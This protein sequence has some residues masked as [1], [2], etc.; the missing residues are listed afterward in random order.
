VTL[1]A[2]LYLRVSTDKQSTENQRP[3]VELLAKARAFEVTQVYEETMSAAKSRPIFAQ[4]PG[5]ELAGGR[6]GLGGG[7]RDPLPRSGW[8]GRE[9]GGVGHDPVA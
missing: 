9:G 6:E 5:A 8:R 3:E 4:R 2:A 1:R 7:V